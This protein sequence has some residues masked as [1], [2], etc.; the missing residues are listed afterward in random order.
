MV[1]KVSSSALKR[2]EGDLK[3]VRRAKVYLDE[4]KAKLMRKEDG[5]EKKISKE[6]AVLSLRKKIEKVRRG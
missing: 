4:E 6:K 3:R 1:E 2:L 5:I